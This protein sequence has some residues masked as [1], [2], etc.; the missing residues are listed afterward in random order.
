M[1]YV[2]EQ[3]LSPKFKYQADKKIKFKVL[4]MKFMYQI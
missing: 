4:V 3:V 1:L 2:Y